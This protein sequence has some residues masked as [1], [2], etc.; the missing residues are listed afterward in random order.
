[1]D[2]GKPEKPR[3]DAVVLDIDGTLWDSR[4]S[5][6]EAWREVVAEARPGVP[7][8][9]M[10]ALTSF[11][12]KTLDE[13]ADGLFPEFPPQ[14]RL[15]WMRRCI[16]AEH[17]HLAVRPGVPYPGV[18]ETCEALARRVPL[19]IASNCEKG[20]PAIAAAGC[21]ITEFV[22]DSLCFGETGTPKSE[23]IRA[24]CARNGVSAP[25]YVGDTAMDE[26]A[27]RAAGVPFIHAAYGFGS[28]SAPMASIRSFAE[29]PA[30]LGLA[31]ES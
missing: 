16:D 17:A 20:Y 23:T 31:P 10:Q 26:E 28:A 22:R 18:R 30:V 3:F 12:G 27:C 14:E 25:V 7:P 13:N 6:A 21:G 15:R 8:P 2:C 9:S 11:F 4:A 19:L 29:L 1:M 5:V 24:V